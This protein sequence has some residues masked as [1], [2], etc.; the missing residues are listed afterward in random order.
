ML[1]VGIGAG[2]A[3]LPQVTAHV[4]EAGFLTP[5]LFYLAATI[6]AHDAVFRARGSDPVSYVVP[7]PVNLR[8]KGSESE[9]QRVLQRL[10]EETGGALYTVYDP[11]DLTTHAVVVGMTGSGKTGLCVGLSGQRAQFR[12]PHCRAVREPR[13]L[14]AP[15]AGTPRRRDRR[16]GIGRWRR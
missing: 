9:T 13:P 8:P 4:Q 2:L 7:L 10:S 6:R 3:E 15:D 5:M 11:D 14:R 1:L 16:C 12:R